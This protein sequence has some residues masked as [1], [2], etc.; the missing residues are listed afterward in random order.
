MPTRF[1]FGGLAH[2]D[3]ATP[4]FPIIVESFGTD[5]VLE[6]VQVQY[7]ETQYGF[8]LRHTTQG[9]W[10]GYVLVEF[11][12]WVADEFYCTYVREIP[13]SYT[14]TSNSL[15]CWMEPNLSGRL[16]HP[17]ILTD[18]AADDFWIGFDFQDKP[19][20]AEVALEALHSF[21]AGVWERFNDRAS[22]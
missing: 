18:K 15:I 2:S 1:D 17:V 13:V 22:A 7:S 6:R 3:A 5:G 16:T 4:A 11:T 12:D 9:H 19:I 14:S 21:A 10:C 20:T 8:I